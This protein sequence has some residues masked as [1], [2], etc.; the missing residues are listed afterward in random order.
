MTISVAEWQ[1]KYINYSGL[2]K[3]L[4]NVN[5]EQSEP[6]IRITSEEVVLDGLDSNREVSSCPQLQTEDPSLHSPS[7]VDSSLVKKDS[8]TNMK[9]RSSKVLETVNWIF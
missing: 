4:D 5:S 1:E 7:R 3:L 8:E 2:K 9:K 6:I